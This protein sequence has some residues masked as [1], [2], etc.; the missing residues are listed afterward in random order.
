M[1]VNGEFATWMF[2]KIDFLR[3]RDL[4]LLNAAGKSIGDGMASG[5]QIYSI[6]QV[7]TYWVQVEKPVSSAQSKLGYS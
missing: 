6:V 1:K 4:E 5:F 2:V 3:L 7:G